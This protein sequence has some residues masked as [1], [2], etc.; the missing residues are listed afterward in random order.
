[1]ISTVEF[2]TKLGSWCLK[3][4]WSWATSSTGKGI[5]MATLQAGNSPPPRE[6]RYCEGEKCLSQECNTMILA[7]ACC[8]TARQGSILNLEP[9]EGDRGIRTSPPL[10][11]DQLRIFFTP[12]P[13]PFRSWFFFVPYPLRTKTKCCK[14][15]I[16]FSQF[17]PPSE[18][19]FPP[20]QLLIPAPFPFFQG[21]SPPCPPP[22]A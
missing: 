16:I 19:C 14:I 1:M 5:S 15:L 18:S 10:T 4:W 11:P 9:E 22:W 12:T 21:S 3:D 2:A 20:F 8:W 17:P 7:R 13:T 6:K